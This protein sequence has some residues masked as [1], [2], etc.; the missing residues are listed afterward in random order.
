MT[1]DRNTNR[2]TISGNVSGSN[3]NIGGTQTIHGNMS[4]SYSAIQATKE[5]K[6]L[7]L[8]KL[9]RELLIELSK[10]SSVHHEEIEAL[11]V[12][13]KCG[14]DEIKKDQPNKKL[15]EIA[16]ESLKL[17]SRDTP[18]LTIIVEEIAK[19]LMLV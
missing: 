4:I 16:G 1:N 7:H 13:T 2:I 6:L 17:A 9:H 12:L 19:I 15:L 14:I 11:D 18:G 10:L 3:V 8:Q 5:Q